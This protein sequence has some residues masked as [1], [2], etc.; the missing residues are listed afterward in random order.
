[1]GPRHNAVCWLCKCEVLRVCE[2]DVLR[3]AHMQALTYSGEL[4]LGSD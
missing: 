4:I 3:A 1:M 2:C